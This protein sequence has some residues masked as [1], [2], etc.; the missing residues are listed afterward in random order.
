MFERMDK[1]LLFIIAALVLIG[2]VMVYSASSIQ[3]AK[4]KNDPTHYLR[5]DL[6]NVAVASLGMFIA[7]RI[8]YRIYKKL[9]WPFLIVAAALLFAV[10]IPGIGAG[11]S[12]ELTDGSI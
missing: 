3:Y 2:V 7:C 11:K 1:K 10:W 8:D 5:L 4:R 12:T 9:A 6:F